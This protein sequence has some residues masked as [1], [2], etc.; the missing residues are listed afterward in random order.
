MEIRKVLGNR[1]YL[2][3]PK[4]EESK[5]IVDENTK[6][7]LNKELIRKM[8]KLTVYAVGNTISDI[9][10][11]DKVLVDPSSLSKALIVPLT[12]EKDVV[13]VS[14]FDIIHIW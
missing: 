11:G 10:V 4:K 9:E 8:A 1:V 6:E 2:E 3:L 14:Y 7:A 12:E 5:L 13:L